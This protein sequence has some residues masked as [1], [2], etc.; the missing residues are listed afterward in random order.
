MK[1][2]DAEIGHLFLSRFKE[3]RTAEQNNPERQ[4][5]SMRSP[6][7]CSSDLPQRLSEGTKEPPYT[8]AR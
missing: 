1:R 7:S 3:K 4:I 8:K 2:I 5:Y 6:N